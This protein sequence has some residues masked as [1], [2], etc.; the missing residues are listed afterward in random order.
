MEKCESKGLATAALLVFSMGIISQWAIGFYTAN[1]YDS[2]SL[3][4]HGSRLHNAFPAIHFQC[5]Q[6]NLKKQLQKIKG[7]FS[8]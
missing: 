7:L 1:Y 8:V 6:N 5:D 3:S 4:K 2:S